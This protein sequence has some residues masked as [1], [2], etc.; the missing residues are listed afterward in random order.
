MYSSQQ[1]AD[2]LY[3]TSV[4]DCINLKNVNFIMQGIS[5]YESTFLYLLLRQEDIYLLLM[6]NLLHLEGPS[7]DPKH[8]WDISVSGPSVWLSGAYDNYPK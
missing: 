4:V 8:L 7:E 6:P 5:L 3:D 2:K 1:Q